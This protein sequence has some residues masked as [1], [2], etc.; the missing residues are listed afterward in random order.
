MKRILSVAF[1][2]CLLL[3]TAC[4]LGPDMDHLPEGELIKSAESPDGTY[5]INA[6][7]C[8][9]GATTDHSVRCEVERIDSKEVRNIY[10]QYKIQD[11]EIHW[12]SNTVVDINGVELDVT[13][14]RYDWRNE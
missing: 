3:L 14:D 1:A 13:K 8:D 7:R 12:K 11:A 6:Y 4:A 5:R 10:W 9:G 2:V